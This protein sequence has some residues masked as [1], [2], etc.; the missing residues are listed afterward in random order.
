MKRHAVRITSAALMGEELHL[1][2]RRAGL[3]QKWVAGKCGI[4][5]SMLSRFEA[6]RVAACPDWA[7]QAL[8]LCGMDLMLVPAART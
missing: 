1:A 5:Q 2:R 6:R 3:S 8:A 4:S 7:F